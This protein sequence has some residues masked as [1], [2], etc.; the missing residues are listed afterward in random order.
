MQNDGIICIRND[1]VLCFILFSEPDIYFL[2]DKFLEIY[3]FVEHT[4]C[5]FCLALD[6][7]KK[8]PQ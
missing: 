3:A 2:N 6:D 5:L 8:I 4:T 1:D 7:T